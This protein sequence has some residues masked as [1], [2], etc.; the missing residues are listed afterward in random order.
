[1]CGFMQFP[2][3][4][5]HREDHEAYRW[6]TGNKIYALAKWKRKKKGKLNLNIKLCFCSDLGSEQGGGL[7]THRVF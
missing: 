6:S 4:Q 3:R 1:M 2:L 5:F 7:L